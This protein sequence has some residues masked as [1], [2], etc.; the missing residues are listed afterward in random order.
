MNEET[1]DLS[2]L[3]PFF[4]F[5]MSKFKKKFSLGYYDVTKYFESFIPKGTKIK[6]VLSFRFREIDAPQGTASTHKNNALIF[7]NKKSFLN[8]MEELPGSDPYVLTVVESTLKHETIHLL[9]FMSS[10]KPGDKKPVFKMTIQNL[11]KRIKKAEKGGSSAISVSE[12]G[13]LMNYI[14]NPYEFN[15][16]VHLIKKHKNNNS[17]EWNKFVKMSDRKK[18]KFFVSSF[19][20]EGASILSL[21]DNDFVGKIESMKK[22]VLKD[23][24]F[25]KKVLK[26]LQR[27][28]LLSEGFDQ[29]V[30]KY[31]NE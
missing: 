25:V 28:G 8:S 31:L 30:R 24:S 26:R 16:A 27:E 2:K 14:N 19:F 20:L 22:H 9:D 13:D 6:V 21:M 3:E 5:A 29:K 4:E 7:I 10:L 11:K 12:L 23:P 15:T 1:H 18:V 17:K